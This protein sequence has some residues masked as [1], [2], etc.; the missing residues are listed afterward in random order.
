MIPCAVQNSRHS[1]G[2]LRGCDLAQTSSRQREP[3]TTK[4]VNSFTSASSLVSLYICANVSDRTCPP[5][6]STQPRD[7]MPIG[8]L[9]VLLGGHPRLDSAALRLA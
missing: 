6:D 8:R 4:T 1:R 9:E 5:L 3:A 7:S 2:K